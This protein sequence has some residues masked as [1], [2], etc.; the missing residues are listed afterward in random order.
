[1]DV[2]ELARRM[3]PKYEREIE[4]AVM[5]A[6]SPQQPAGMR[7]DTETHG[8]ASERAMGLQ[9][10]AEQPLSSFDAR[11]YPTCNTEAESQKPEARSRKP[12]AGSQSC[13][14][15]AGNRKP[16][17]GSKPEARSRKPEP[18]AGNWK[19]KPRSQSQR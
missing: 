6:G 5:R 15:E 13:K 3:G 4:Q 16:E 9:V 2:Q 7:V 10:T 1:M 19:Q 12:E 8:G 11:C 14:P 17:V 18:E